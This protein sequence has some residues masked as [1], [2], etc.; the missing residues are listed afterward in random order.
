MSGTIFFICSTLAISALFA[1]PKNFSLISCTTMAKRIQEQKEGERVVSKSRLVMNVSSF[2]DKFLCRIKSIASKSP[3][4]SGASGKPASRMNLEVSSFDA[5]SASQVRLKDAYLGGLKE[6]QQG[7]LTHKKEHTSE[8]TGDSE[9]EP[10][11]YKAVAQTNEA[12]GK[13]L[14]GETA[15]S[16]SSAFQKSQNNKEATLKHFYAISPQTISFSEAV[17]DMVR[18]IYGRPS[19]DPM[20]DLDVNVSRRSISW[21]WWR[22]SRNMK[23][24]QDI[25]RNFGYTPG[26][27]KWRKLSRNEY[28]HPSLAHSQ[29]CR[30]RN[31]AASKADPTYRDRVER[32]QQRKMDFCAKEVEQMD[33]ARRASLEPSVVPRPP[34]AETEVED[35]SSVKYQFQ[36]L[37][38]RWPLRRFFLCHPVWFRP[39]RFQFRSLREPLQV[40]VWNGRKVKVPHMPSVPGV[41]SGSDV[42]RACWKSTALPNPSVVS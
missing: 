9:A 24:T 38:R 6:E 12:C 22:T 36:V 4:M 39:V 26:C 16:I 11:Y 19:D 29:D 37:M 3:G 8:E 13:P 10:W 21:A 30:I 35:R 1:A 23:I 5:A 34:A 15:E 20:E 7:N 31:E 41:T 14:A 28:S 25:L 33:H 42:K 17:Y 40:V 32:A 18:K 2:C 27:A